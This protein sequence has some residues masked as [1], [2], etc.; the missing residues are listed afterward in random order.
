M[1]RL[2]VALALAASPAAAE[3][4]D[5]ADKILGVTAATLVITDW[6]QTR[7]IAKHPELY[8]EKNILLGEH[9]SVR[10][11]DVYFSGLLIGGYLLADWLPSSER[12]TFLSIVSII[13]FKATRDNK[14]LG[15]KVEF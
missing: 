14:Q 13:W 11:V 9:P 12:K 8:R 10:K 15:V 6:G 7:Y 2:L 1:R 5:T 3:D 4:W